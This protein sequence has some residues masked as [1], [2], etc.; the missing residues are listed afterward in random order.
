[1]NM[2]KGE[3]YFGDGKVVSDECIG[4]LGLTIRIDLR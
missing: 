4:Q 2:T 3:W 1:M